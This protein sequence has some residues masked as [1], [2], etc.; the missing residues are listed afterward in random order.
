MRSRF[1]EWQAGTADAIPAHPSFRRH[2][3]RLVLYGR[4]FRLLV[5]RQPCGPLGA[6]DLDPFFAVAA[7]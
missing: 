6:Q 2:G 3:E 4:G 7:C 1:C 5:H